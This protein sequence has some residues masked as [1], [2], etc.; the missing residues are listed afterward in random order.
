VFLQLWTSVLP[1]DVAP[2]LWTW[3]SDLG[4]RGDA[5]CARE[6]LNEIDR[7]DDGLADW[8]RR[9]A[10]QIVEPIPA[11]QEKVTEILAEYERLIN[12]R[13][14]TGM[15]DPWVVAVALHLECS[16]VSQESATEATTRACIP[17]V[18]RKYDIDCYNI[19]Q[20]LRKEGVSIKLTTS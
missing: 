19:G 9:S 4:G 15:A 11:I 8:I 14:N 7:K 20:M 12:E 6:V 5:C 18:C 17:V 13:R 1:H 10:I 2:E 16:V 3:L